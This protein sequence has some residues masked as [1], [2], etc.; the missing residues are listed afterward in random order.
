MDRAA[1]APHTVPSHVSERDGRHIEGARVSSGM[2][3]STPGEAS[4]TASDSE[5]DDVV[6]EVMGSVR[7]ARQSVA[8]FTAADAVAMARQS[9]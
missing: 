1:V 2:G 5:V 9:Q 3:V 4:A 6:R 8:R 7:H